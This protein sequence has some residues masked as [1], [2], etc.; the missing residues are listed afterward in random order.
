MENA[1]DEAV[2]SLQPFYFLCSFLFSLTVQL[3]QTLFSFISHSLLT[4]QND[5][6]AQFKH[7]D[8]ILHPLFYSMMQNL[9]LSHTF[10]KFHLTTY[11][12]QETKACRHWQVLLSLLMTSF[13]SFIC[14]YLLCLRSA[15]GLYKAGRAEGSSVM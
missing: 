4:P 10:L 5:L 3:Q 15:G 9:Y 1:H 6:L 14:L 8:F 12:Q 13:H 7:F 11:N 2:S